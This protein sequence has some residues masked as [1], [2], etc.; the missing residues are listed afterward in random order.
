[1]DIQTRQT[2]PQQAE[3]HGH[4]TF[5]QIREIRYQFVL[6]RQI[7][8]D[9]TVIRIIL[10]VQICQYHYLQYQTMSIVILLVTIAI[11]AAII[12]VTIVGG[13]HGGGN[14]GFGGFNGHHGGG[15]PGFGGFNGHP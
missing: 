9:K 5:R 15:N 1:M 12:L 6:I 8:L 7:L 4:L 13:H 11:P 14:P 10:L 3:H 2:Y